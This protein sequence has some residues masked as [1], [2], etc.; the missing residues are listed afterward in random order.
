MFIAV[1]FDG[2][3][4]TISKSDTPECKHLCDK[5]LSKKAL[6]RLKEE[7]FLLPGFIDLHIHAPQWPQ[8]G[9]ALDKPLYEWL[10][11]NTF[12][13]EARYA[14]TA[15]ARAVYEKMVSSLLSNG[16]TTALYFATIHN[17]ASLALAEICI[18][19]GQRAFVGRVAMDNPLQCP[20]YYRD[21]S[22][23][24]AI[25][26]TRQF[27]KSVKSLAGNKDGFVKPVIT[28]RF[29]PSCTDPLLDGL[30]LIASE[31]GCHIQTHCSESDWEH[32]YVIDRLGRS[33]T[34]ALRDFGLLTRHTILA[35][36]N[37]LGPSDMD[38]I[39]EAGSGIAHCPLSNA[40]FSNSVFPLRT[41]LEKGLR[42]GLG[43]DISGGHSPSIFDTCRMAVTS[44]R[45]LEDGVDPSISQGD[46]GTQ[47]RRIDFREAFWLATVGG[48]DVLD[49]PTGLFAKENYFDAIVIDT[50]VDQSNIDLKNNLDTLDDVFQKIIH[51]AG[52]TNIIQTWVSGR[53]IQ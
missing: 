1:G 41:A 25:D 17:E 22:A 50:S 9:K 12:P 48:A 15:F 33:D 31:C 13:L 30:G 16:T 7:Q 44:S 32:S 35:H 24:A 8:L 27:I 28:P 26:G 46:R 36:S 47:L 14:E 42:V 20:D 3:I 52:R 38:V 23:E 51:N 11:K 53:L 34:E 10:Q 49:I 21:V 45:M 40:Y 37:F 43:T 4:K 2:R 5:L 6:H 19:K 18:E 29:I 39:K